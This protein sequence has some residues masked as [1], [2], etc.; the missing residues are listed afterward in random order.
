MAR[1]TGRRQIRGS[2]AYRTAVP[3]PAST[4]ALAMAHCLA[5]LSGSTF[6]GM[7]RRGRP[8]RNSSLWSNIRTELRLNSTVSFSTKASTSI[9]TVQ[10]VAR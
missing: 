10:M 3:G 2:S 6:L 9:A 4:T 8:Q 5:A 7:D 1:I